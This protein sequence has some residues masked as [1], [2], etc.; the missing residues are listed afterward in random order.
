[1]GLLNLF[2]KSSAAIH[3]LPSGSL[4]VDRNGAI[5][6]TTVPSTFPPDIL[7]EVGRQVVRLFNDARA[8]QLPLSELSLQF[9]SLQITA[10]EMRGGALIFLKPKR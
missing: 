4:T 10:R 8:A 5:I 1:M 3:L 7:H 6:A 2:S 9:A